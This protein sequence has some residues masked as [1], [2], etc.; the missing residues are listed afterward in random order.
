[1]DNY[2]IVGNLTRDPVFGMVNCKGGTQKAR[3]YFTIATDN[4]YRKDANGNTAVKFIRVTTWDKLAEACAK[5]LIKG[6]GVYAEGDI[7]VSVYKSKVDGGPRA[8]LELN[9][10]PGGKVQFLSPPSGAAKS[11]ATGVA[12]AQ[13]VIEAE[14]DDTDL[15]Y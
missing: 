9:I 4:P 5:H 14:Y 8:Q 7:G 13:P 10:G 11:A 1:M 12:V 6:K 2:T 3:C 15:P